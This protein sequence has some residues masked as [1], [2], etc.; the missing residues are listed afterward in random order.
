MTENMAGI[1]TLRPNVTREEAAHEL[2][3]RGLR[4]ILLNVLSGPLR[5]LAQIYVP[6]RLYRVHIRDGS[7][8]QS[9]LLAVDAVSGKLDLFSFPTFSDE[10]IAVETKTRNHVAASL[11]EEKA[12]DILEASVRRMIFRAGFFRVCDL[13]IESEL[14]IPELHVPFWV[15]FRGNSE[16]ATPVV[17]DAV[18]RRH[19]GARIRQ[20]ILEWLA[21]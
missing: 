5:R 21:P 6:F 13:R 11:P 20:L 15:G 2:R 3:S 4:R 19:E 8:K 7:R 16:S 14:L 17:L 10:L 1:C 12:R 18:R 9:M